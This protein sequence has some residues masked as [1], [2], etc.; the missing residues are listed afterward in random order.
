MIVRFTDDNLGN[1]KPHQSWLHHLR[2]PKHCNKRQG[3]STSWY[4]THIR[5]K[6][7]IHPGVLL[8]GD[9]R[10][11]VGQAHAVSIV[12]GRY[13]IITSRVILRPPY[14]NYK[15]NISYY[16][17]KIGDYVYIGNDSVVEAATIGNHVYIGKNC[18][19]VITFERIFTY[20]H[21]SRDDLQS[22]KIVASFTTTR[23]FTPTLSFHHSLPFLDPRVFQRRLQFY[24]QDARWENWQ[25]RC[26]KKW[27]GLHQI[28]TINNH[29]TV[30]LR[31]E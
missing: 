9:L 30:R 3:A 23:S 21:V 12:M 1:R 4:Y 2:Q 31:F 25:N 28:F 14:K 15:G 29:L 7:I 19:I 24:R 11:S 18:V 8:R 26:K 6:S 22:L 5:Q 16:P 20:D 10:R 13:C 27:S 17:V